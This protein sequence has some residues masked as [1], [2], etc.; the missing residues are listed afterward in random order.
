MHAAPPG[1]I[2]L[3][4]LEGHRPQ[5]QPPGQQRCEAVQQALLLQHVGHLAVVCGCKGGRQQTAQER[6]TSSMP[7][8]HMHAPTPPTH[9]I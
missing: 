1:M 2:M 8:G 5:Q 4:G 3:R 6:V 7:C 9:T